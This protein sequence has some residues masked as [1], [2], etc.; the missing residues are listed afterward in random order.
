MGRDYKIDI[1]KLKN[2][3]VNVRPGRELIRPYYYGSEDPRDPDYSKQEA[4]Y[5]RLRYDGFTVI[6]KRVRYYGDKKKEKGVD[7]AIA[8]DLVYYGLQGAYDVAILVSGDSDLAGA[9][10]KVKMAR[11]ECRIEVAM[12]R[13]SM[14]RELL[15]VADAFYPLDDV[16]DE[17]RKD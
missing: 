6:V 7:V 3:L 16:A 2:Y 9:I 13:K 15:K 17:I 12:F 10:E 14:S 11:A 5:D 4:F 1:I 8:T